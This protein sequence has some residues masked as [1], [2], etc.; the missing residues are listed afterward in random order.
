MRKAIVLTLVA[1]CSNDPVYVPGPMP[2]EAGQDDGT[3]MAA[4]GKASLQLPIKL[5]TSKDAASRA[6]RSTQLAPVEVPYVK[7]DDIEV[8]VEW[9]VTNLSNM[10]GDFTIQLNGANEYWEYDPELLAVGLDEEEPKPPGLDGD[11]PLHVEAMSTMSGLF[12]EDQ[13]KEASIDLDEITRGNFNPFRAT[14]T[15]SKNAKEFA[16]LT[17]QTYNADGEPLPQM[18]TGV[19]YPR[20][21]IANLVRIDLVFKPTQHMQLE[22]TVRIRDIRGI[23]HELLDAAMTEAPGELTMFTPMTYNP[24]AAP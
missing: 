14:L 20:E 16:Q 22:Y 18:T 17:P 13:V 4:V 2:I 10:P 5:E 15:I 9:K 12:R 19:V 23:M 3:G 6:T 7:V 24:M 11:I 8:S 1:A 21:A